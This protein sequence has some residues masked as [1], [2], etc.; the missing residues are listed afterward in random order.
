ML[1]NETEHVAE[2]FIET[3]HVEDIC[4]EVGFVSVEVIRLNRSFGLWTQP[5]LFLS[6]GLHDTIRPLP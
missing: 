1:F 6:L 4:F 5:L 2:V 3:D